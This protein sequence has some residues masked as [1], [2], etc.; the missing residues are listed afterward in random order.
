MN[1]FIKKHNDIIKNTVL[2]TIAVVILLNIL[3]IILN[4]TY[5]TTAELE[6]I[7]TTI[8]GITT[9]VI[10]SWALTESRKSNKIIMQQN[11]IMMHQNKIMMAQSVYDDFVNEINLL[12]DKGEE[13]VFNENNS[14]F[15]K[16]Q[17][18]IDLSE[19]NY[20][21]FCYNTDIILIFIIDSEYYQK[22]YIKLNDVEKIVVEK[23]DIMQITTLISYMNVLTTGYRNYMRWAI[24]L[25]YIQES[26]LA[27]E[28]L[29]KQQK[30]Q[31]FSMM[32]NKCGDFQSYF[33]SVVTYE[34]EES[35]NIFSNQ[36]KT[37]I[38]RRVLA[39]NKFFIMKKGELLALPLKTYK[40]ML[41]Q[42]IKLTNLIE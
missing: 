21:N 40:R 25:F 32:E 17:Q 7:V 3:I 24:Q 20:L 37:T 33:N 10:I 16:T 22:Y 39:E 11:V 38:F 19:I 1:K 13:H 9:I 27:N 30:A 42:K 26:I 4:L 23:D 35:E 15:L 2:I 14:D 34:S 31:L 41:E 18:S 8:T 12:I 36:F 6:L 29:L 5:L 28:S